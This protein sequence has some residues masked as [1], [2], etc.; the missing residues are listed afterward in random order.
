VK[1]KGGGV[2][3]LGRGAV[4]DKARKCKKEWAQHTLKR[5]IRDIFGTKRRGG[6]GL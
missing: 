5:R 4:G 1:T 6:Q 3:T 2:K